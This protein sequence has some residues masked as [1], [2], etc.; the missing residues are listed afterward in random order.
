MAFAD[1]DSFLGGAVRQS[2]LPRQGA[3]GV[4]NQIYSSGQLNLPAEEIASVSFI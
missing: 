1:T 4:G 2:L 3:T